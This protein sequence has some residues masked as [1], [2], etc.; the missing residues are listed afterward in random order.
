M[1][2]LRDIWG[3]PITITSGHRCAAH[4]KSVGGAPESMHL[5]LA[6]D[7]LCPREEQEAF[8]LA[9]GQCGFTGIGVYPSK[10]FVHLDKG[11]ARTWQG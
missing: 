4:N 6:F 10:G 1:Q 9:A 7:C 2:K 5:K 11:K 3:K 8:V